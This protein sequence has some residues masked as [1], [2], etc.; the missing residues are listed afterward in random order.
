MAKPDVPDNAPAAVVIE[1]A[2][3]VAT[4][5]ETGKGFAATTFVNTMVA[6][7]DIML[8]ISCICHGICA[9]QDGLVIDLL[10]RFSAVFW[11]SSSLA[12]HNISCGTI[13]GF[14]DLEILVL[15]E[16]LKGGDARNRDERRLPQKLHD[17]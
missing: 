6:S 4:A 7:L 15:D 17:W 8:F 13:T 2:P 1:S 14:N 16:L 10:G 5:R 11:L 3:D 9:W 12:R